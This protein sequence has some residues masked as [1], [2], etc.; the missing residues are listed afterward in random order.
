MNIT[1]ITTVALAIG[2]PLLGQ[3]LATSQSIG[4]RASDAVGVNF[5]ARVSRCG[6]GEAG[7]QPMLF[8]TIESMP[9]DGAGA[10]ERVRGG[11]VQKGREKG[12]RVIAGPGG[13]PNVDYPQRGVDFTIASSP[14]GGMPV[15]KFEDASGTADGILLPAVQKG[16]DAAARHAINTKGTGATNGRA[17]D[18][19]A[20]GLPAVAS[21]SVS[22]DAD[23]P[24]LTFAIPLAAFG[25]GAKTGH[26]TL[27]KRSDGAMRATATYADGTTADITASCT[28]G[29]RLKAGYDL[30]VAKK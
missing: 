29:G 19:P 28:A 26:V 30:A 22:G 10:A 15:V 12:M 1:A 3:E 18:A 5:D 27:M 4:Q 20:E 7:G 2:M 13:G 6:V 8:A 16:R 17:C 21:C 11:A 24:D 9:L 14:G 25:S 23:A